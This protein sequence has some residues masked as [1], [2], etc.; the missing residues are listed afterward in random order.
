MSESK[1][2]QMPS[3]AFGASL[4]AKVFASRKGHGNA[5]ASEIHLKQ[6]D[7]A[8]LLAAAYELGIEAATQIFERT[9][10]AAIG[11]QP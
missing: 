11:D 4:A 7:L 1:H 10:A 8:V 3:D 9:A 2:T 6:A 5:P